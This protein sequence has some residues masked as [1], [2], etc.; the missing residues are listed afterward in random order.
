MSEPLL[1]YVVQVKAFSRSTFLLWVDGNEEADFLVQRLEHGG[2][3]HASSEKAI[4]AQISSRE[5]GF[6]VVD[7]PPVVYSIDALN[8]R[9]RQLRPSRKPSRN[10][11]AVI[12][13][14]W[15]LLD[16]LGESLQL[17][18]Q[19]SIVFKKSQSKLAHRVYSK[20]FWLCGLPSVSRYAEAQRPML[21]TTTEIALLRYL[22]PARWAELIG[23][24][25]L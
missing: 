1:S 13:N 10:A 9:L 2:L 4:R 16:D 5:R 25:G 19:A 24:V 12:L 17:A 21:L 23:E 7:D 8:E 15:N 20:L 18:G 11:A 14:H 6:T 22:L 3:L